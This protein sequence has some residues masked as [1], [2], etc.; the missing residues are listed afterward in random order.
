MINYLNNKRLINNKF[1]YK[2]TE[3]ISYIEEPEIITK[4]SFN[5]AP[6]ISTYYFNTKPFINENI[7][8]PFYCSNYKQSEYLK[9]NV[10]KLWLKLKKM[11]ILLEE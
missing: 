4:D 1:Y 2:S 10:L 5:K 7:I 3:N 8:I 11:E 6:W 9:I